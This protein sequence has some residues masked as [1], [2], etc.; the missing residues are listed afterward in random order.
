MTATLTQFKNDDGIEI[1]IDTTTGESFASQSGY[2][3]MANKDKSTISRRF[4][5]VA[6]E[7]KK[8]AEVS[9][10]VGLRSVALITEDLIVEW[11]PKDNPEMATQLMKLGVRHFLHV[12]AGYEVKSAAVQPVVQAIALPPADVRV[13]N[14]QAA[15]VWFD[16]DINNPR[17]KQELQDLTLDIL[18][19][20]NSSTTKSD[21]FGVAERAE[22]KGY[23]VAL[24][25]QHRSK[26]GKFVAKTQ[27]PLESRKERRLCNGTQREI[28]VYLVTEEFDNA[29]DDYFN[30]LTAALN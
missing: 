17:F 9:T 3:R 24:V 8:T 18:G 14:L 26:L 21:W 13:S 29:I 6:L 5:C 20:G 30:Q 23:P 10:G 4:E 2:A 27:P 16:I 28:N 19:V 22:Q 12:V 7:T 25:T 15:L 1:Y 11:L